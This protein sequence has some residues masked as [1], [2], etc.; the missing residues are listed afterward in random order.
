MAAPEYGAAFF[1]C[2]IFEAVIYCNILVQGGYL[3][4]KMLPLVVAL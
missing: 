4:Y 2:L 3:F 1:S